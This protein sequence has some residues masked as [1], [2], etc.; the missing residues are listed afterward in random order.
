MHLLRSA[1]LAA[2]AVFAGC[3]SVDMVVAPDAA[4]FEPTVDAPAKIP[5]TV[6]YFIADANRSAVTRTAN[7]S[8]SFH[9]YRDLEPA[10]RA[11]LASVFEGVVRLDATS[12][13]T[14]IRVGG[15]RYLISP[16][17]VTS[18]VPSGNALSPTTSFTV[19]LTNSIRCPSGV[20]VGRVQ[21]VAQSRTGLLESAVDEGAAGRRA[22][23][24]ALMKM[25]HAMAQRNW[26][27][28]SPGGLCADATRL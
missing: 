2:L 28:A 1:L 14:P 5:A 25:Q 4:A 10:Y 13:P 23:Q 9:P 27:E 16:E 18:V 22:I 6:G 12:Q 3:A 19:E 21:V 17:L 7:G 26:G 15:V 24:E 11:M 8:V 20:L